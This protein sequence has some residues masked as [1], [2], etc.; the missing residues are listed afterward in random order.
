MS[1]E[2]AIRVVIADS[3]EIVREGIANRLVASCNV[4]IVGQASD[5]YTAI[6]VCRSCRPDILLMD[7]SLQRPSGAETLS[8]LRS[9]LSDM[10]IVVL[11]SDAT[12]SDAFSTLAA[13]AVAFMPKQARGIH[14]VNAIRAASEGYTLLPTEYLAEFVSLR[15]NITRTGNIYGLSPREIE[16]LE[17]CTSGQK[18]KE[19][20]E[21]LSISVRTVE[22]HRNSI[23][24]K[25]NSRSLSDLSRI[26]N[27][28]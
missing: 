5:G 28:L 3:H 6:K 19:V 12:T 16:I 21:N 23:Y 2:S 11:S 15:R 9:T 8:K 7:L 18:T 4:E 27:Q 22:T 20:A 24:R 10:K 1:E 14:F 17:A 26:V 25:T 13:G